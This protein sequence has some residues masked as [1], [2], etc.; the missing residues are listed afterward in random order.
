M[1]L[2]NNQEGIRLELESSDEKILLT[3]ISEQHPA[4]KVSIII[5]PAL[6]KQHPRLLIYINMGKY[7]VFRNQDNEDCFCVIE[8]APV[9]NW[10]E[11]ISTEK[12][13]EENVMRSEY[14]REW[15]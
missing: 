9:G 7:R 15:D 10:Q 5:D 12:P 1:Q 14:L 11:V 8:G 2:K 6:D 4:K 3:Y 13:V